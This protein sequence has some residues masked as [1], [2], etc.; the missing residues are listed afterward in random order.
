M[1]GRWDGLCRVWTGV[2]ATSVRVRASSRKGNFPVVDEPP[3]LIDGARVIAYAALPAAS[4]TR[5]H[6]VVAGMPLEAATGVAV[7]EN[8]ADAATFVLYCD[9][10]WRTLAVEEHGG[11]AAAQSAARAQYPDLEWIAYRQLTEAEAAEIETTRRFLRGLA[12][13]FPG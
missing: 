10:Q 3:F 4:S 13:D 2:R 1:P 6:A 5:M 9:A 7:T 11:A 12:S 8:L